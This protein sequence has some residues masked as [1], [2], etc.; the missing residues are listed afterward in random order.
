MNNLVNGNFTF[1][2]G[3]TISSQYITGNSLTNANGSLRSI[4]NTARKGVDITGQLSTSVGAAGGA[5]AL[6][7]TPEGY[8]TLVIDG[9]ERK[10]PYFNA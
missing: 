5:S 7:V 4:L 10:V 3:N 8:L 9:T 2:A 6:P 1:G